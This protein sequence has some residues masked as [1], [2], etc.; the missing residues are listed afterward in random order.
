MFT[1]THEARVAVS[2]RVQRKASGRGTWLIAWLLSV[3]CFPTS[4]C[5]A[6]G[7]A[8]FRLHK[9]DAA[10]LAL[11]DAN[12]EPVV[13]LAV[14]ARTGSGPTLAEH[15]RRLGGR[16]D[17]RLDAVD[18]FT[19]I[20]PTEKVEQLLTHSELQAVA[21]DSLNSSYAD[22]VGWMSHGLR[23]GAARSVAAVANGTEPGG[24]PTY[25]PPRPID[26]PYSI[27]RDM[28]AEGFRE[29][30]SRF[31]GRGVTIAQVEW[32]PDFLSP[33]LQLAKDGSG[34]PVPKFADVINVPVPV[35]SLEPHPPSRGEMW[36][37]PLSRPISS[38][39]RRLRY[40]GEEYRVPQAGT[41]RLARLPIPAASESVWSRY[42]LP[43]IY[44]RLHS[45]ASAS[46]ATAE[47][48]MASDTQSITVPV[49]WSDSR[50]LLWLDTNLDLD[51]C[52]EQPVGE[53]S[54]FLQFGVLGQDDPNTPVRESV[55]YAVQLDGDYISLNMGLG[56]HATMVAGAAAGNRGTLGRVDGVAPG[57]QLISIAAGASPSI[58]RYARAMAVA[59]TDPR[60][61]VVLIEGSR[62]IVTPHE[63]KDGQSLLA[64]TLARLAERFPKPV[65]VTAGNSPYM[66]ASFDISIPQ[67]VLSIGA[68]HS[69][70]SIF[71][72]YG[73]RTRHPMDL[74]WAGAEGPAGDGALK[75]DLLA[76]ANPIT[77][78]TRVR[79]SELGSYP[80]VFQLPPGYAIGG[81]TSVAAPVAAGAVA[82]LIGGAR[83]HGRPHH[84]EDVAEALRYSAK[85]LP[86]FSAY[87]QGHGV[88]QLIA[89]WNRLTPASEQKISIDIA[90][91]VRTSW[92][93]TLPRANLGRGLFER[94]GW[95]LGDVQKRT[96]LLTRTNGIKDP[97]S[98]DIRWQGNDGTFRSANSVILPLSK[99]VPMEV[100]IAPQGP[101]AHSAIAYLTASELP[102]SIANIPFTVVVPHAL[103]EEN[104]YAWVDELK[105]ERPGRKSLFFHVPQGAGTF[106]VGLQTVRREISLS[107]LDPTN[108][109]GHFR[110]V[111]PDRRD[112][113]GAITVESPAAGVWEVMLHDNEDVNH[114]DWSIR[115]LDVLPRTPVKVWASIGGADLQLRDDRAV[116]TNLFGT[117]EGAVAGLALGGLRS[118][119]IQ[120]SPAERVV[121]DIDVEE[122][123]QLLAVEIEP[124]AASDL[125][126][127]LHLLECTRDSCWSA[128]RSTN[129]GSDE[130]IIVEH[131]R[132]GRWRAV[133]VASGANRREL[134]VTYM[135]RYT[136]AKLGSLSTTDTIRKREPGERWESHLNVWRA[137]C[138]RPE[139]H[140]IGLLSVRARDREVAGVRPYVPAFRARDDRHGRRAFVAI[141]YI[142]LNECTIV[143]RG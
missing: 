54:R 102:G 32:F 28:D 36:T 59:F 85:F 51:F 103:T 124:L 84:A 117:F 111:N 116:A 31:D 55:G 45:R 9:E 126:A 106:T 1:H 58:A 95:K 121:V 46:G 71:S 3:A 27:L 80:G 129:V 60:V 16:I 119:R 10:K 100:E 25:P 70:D 29:I 108:P 74:H 82:L 5:L 138:P 83:L 12:R 86:Q 105:L 8:P 40:G 22:Q 133:V 21:V 61:D 98:F 114:V 50:R 93:Q 42:V 43:L 90:A 13:V 52:D 2:G 97:M 87:K 92:S 6:S 57:A 39:E 15:A 69:A 64:M 107:L 35:P 26:E 130:R 78:D 33:E 140:P 139:Y 134:H 122:G 128:Y 91:P 72:Y 49:L 137:G 79:L 115:G 53:Y 94:E 113:R 118:R 18:Y 112:G 75:P 17:Y 14:L 104:N 20:M 62:H 11:Y 132:P 131:P 73:L 67:N 101:G 19:L 135:D 76:P 47:K 24:W 125:D 123:Q 110:Y 44:K 99:P 38:E 143:P 63:P 68:T 41:Y 88:I 136:H 48:I 37:S 77:L 81:G 7:Q 141:K 96:V 56:S 4:A 66:S 120:L 127:D 142:P 89:A 109:D 34:K 30:D 65:L 23:R